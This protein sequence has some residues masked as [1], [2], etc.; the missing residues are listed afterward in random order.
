MSLE[1]LELFAEENPNGFIQY[2]VTDLDGVL[3]GKWI[4]VQKALQSM[5]NGL[6]FCDVV[7]GWDIADQC[8]PDLEVTGWQTGYPDAFCQLD[9]DTYRMHES[10][11]SMPL[12]LADFE[13]SDG[14]HSSI[15]P[16]SLLKRIVRKATQMGYHAE[17]AQELEWFNFSES[18]ESIHDKNYQDP[19]TITE[20]MFGY[21][22]LRLGKFQYLLETYL[23]AMASL[24]IQV[25]SFHT[26]TGPGV[27]EAALAHTG[28]LE[29]A[30][31]AI[32]FKYFTKKI[33]SQ[34]G[35]LPS[36]MAKWNPNLPGCGGHIHQSL[37]TLDK[38]VNLFW[39]EN[40][41]N[42]MSDI[43]KHFIAGQ[44]YCLP[45]ILPMYAPT[46]NSYKRLVKGTWAPTSISWGIENRTTA[47]RVIHNDPENM[48]AEMR[49]PGSDVNPYLAMAAAL[50]SGLYG[51]EHKLDLQNATNGSAYMD[52]SLVSLPDSL[53]EATSH[54]Y[55]S[56]VA[57]ELFGYT[58]V[59]HFAKT[60]FWEV[61]QYQEDS[62]W[63]IQRYF[64]AI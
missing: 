5:E 1:K 38:S 60:R 56:T 43:M 53:L 15:C 49:I 23:Q 34:G 58:F 63:E 54:M 57:K 12:I 37:W 26:E 7:F 4:S 62:A 52:E 42:G 11:Q 19:Y 36:F 64:E 21:S 27:Y 2:G 30:D 14:L 61:H 22:L 55:Q 13:D 18:A 40:D 48:R 28:I 16:R 29:A 59:E 10:N 45:H 8:I 25:E 44:L 17:Y 33:F 9:F 35:I 51:I 6:G 41:K 20:G 3:R 39:D 31:R 24:N 32:L 47:V 50:A 46:T